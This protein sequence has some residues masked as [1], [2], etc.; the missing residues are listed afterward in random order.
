M[1]LPTKKASVKNILVPLELHELQIGSEEM[2]LKV[3]HWLNRR[4]HPN[5]E[6]C[7]IHENKAM[8][9]KEDSVRQSVAEK[10]TE[11]LLLRDVLLNGILAIGTLGHHVDSLCPEACIEEDDFL[12]MDE[13]VVVEEEKNEEEP[14]N[15]KVKE[16]AALAIALSE[17]VVPV[18][19]PA[20][21]HSS[22]MKEDNF[23]CFVTEEILMHEVEDGGA[24]NIQERP[25]L[26]VEKVEKVRTTLADLFAAEAF[27]SSAPGEKNCQDIVI[28]AGASTSKP[29]LCTEKAHKKKPT[30]PTPKPLKATRKL[31]RVMRKM[32]GKKI[33]P[34]QLNG[35]SNAEG[36]LTA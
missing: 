17:P 32:L 1:I 7:T 29:A 19:E 15:E 9:D 2:G 25:L 27:S 30:K 8:E 23:S 14:R 12:V 22:S 5:T 11:A 28:V 26:M 35:R 13:E 6:Y 34:E 21:M 3:F 33:H 31:S 36:P 4:M 20:K 10:D 16:D 18:V 24:A